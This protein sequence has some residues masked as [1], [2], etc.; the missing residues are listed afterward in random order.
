MHFKKLSSILSLGGV[1]LSL[2]I[3]CVDRNP[4]DFAGLQ[5]GITASA[6]GDTLIFGDARGNREDIE[7]DW[8]DHVPAHLTDGDALAAAVGRAKG[9]VF[10]GF[11]E[12]GNAKLHERTSF[13][14]DGAR[15]ISRPAVSAATIEAGRRLVEDQGGV[16]IL[17]Y[18]NIPVV[19][20]RIDPAR[21]VAIRKHPLVDYVEPDGFLS[22]ASPPSRVRSPRAMFQGETLPE[23][24]AQIRADDA[25]AVGE[26]G[27]GVTITIIDSGTYNGTFGVHEDLPAFDEC[28]TF[29]GNPNG[30]QDA[31]TGLGGHGTRVTGIAV[32]LRNGIGVI[33]V[34]P[35]ATLRS[36]KVCT[37]DDDPQQ[38]GGCEISHLTSAVEWVAADGD[39]EVVNMS[40]GQQ[41]YNASLAQALYGAYLA[42][43]LLVAA[44]GSDSVGRVYWPAKSTWVI[45]VSALNED[46]TLHPSSNWGAEVELS[47]PGV[48]DLTTDLRDG[49]T[50]WIGGTSG[51][52]P[53][54]AGVAALI[55]SQNPS[56]NKINVRNR[57][58]LTAD[59]LGPYAGR[60]SQTGFGRV[61]AY[62]AVTDPPPLTASISGPS[63]ITDLPDQMLCTWGAIVSGGTPPYQYQWSGFI[64]GTTSVVWLPQPTFEPGTLYLTVTDAVGG[65]VNRSLW[66]S[67][68][69]NAQWCTGG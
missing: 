11:K 58:Q 39:L 69:P 33:G 60:D 31:F 43:D 21:A 55:W 15:M 67:I 57:L 4:T 28:R 22:L 52:S 51:A 9:R 25:H 44:A 27:D 26:E 41:S 6:V 61:N 59:D 54:V 68:N 18:R 50:D 63:A 42:G 47:A 56:W 12:P 53:H 38:E 36:L 10:I 20:A 24:I 32:A 48:T 65:Q 30:C 1:A 7:I 37:G 49:Y 35:Q 16:I 64:S 17:P 29:V 5:E 14:R 23:N 66:I 13:L 3:A 34:A 46:G 2:A 45:A 8:P 62:R 19:V 40:L